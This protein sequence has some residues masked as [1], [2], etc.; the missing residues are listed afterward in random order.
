MRSKLASPAAFAGALE[1]ATPKD[2]KFAW[3]LAARFGAYGESATFQPS[4]PAACQSIVAFGRPAAASSS[5]SNDGAPAD[6]D[7]GSGSLVCES[8]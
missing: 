1:A 3:A 2:E 8:E 4:V 6:G 7:A 5:V